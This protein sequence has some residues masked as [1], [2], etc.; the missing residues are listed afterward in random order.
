MDKLFDVIIK[1]ASGLARANFDVLL[2]VAGI[3]FILMGSINGVSTTDGVFRLIMFTP[4]SPWFIALG[5]VLAGG[6]LLVNIARRDTGSMSEE[7]RAFLEVKPGS[8]PLAAAWQPP[9]ID[10]ETK[11]RAE[12]QREEQ[13]K[14]LGERRLPHPLIDR[15][16]RGLPPRS[17]WDAYRHELRERYLSLTPTNKKIVHHVYRQHLEPRIPVDELWKK[18]NEWTQGAKIDNTDEF[19]QRTLC[20]A[21]AGL[22]D[23]ELVGANKTDVLKDS[24]VGEALDG[25]LS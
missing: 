25:V 13:R 5:G 20:I 2:F 19:V 8:K 23:L 12:E 9:A 22:F 10:E 24:A 6:G 18:F 7:L 4:V 3:V 1:A 17:E 11:R 15:I 16:K 14:R 21:A